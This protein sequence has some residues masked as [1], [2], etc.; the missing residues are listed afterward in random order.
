MMTTDTQA[1]ARK[2]D[3]VLLIFRGYE[4]VW[5]IDRVSA[6]AN[7]RGDEEWIELPDGLLCAGAPHGHHGAF[8]GRDASGDSCG[9][10]DE[11]DDGYYEDDVEY[12]D[13]DTRERSSHG[14]HVSFEGATAVSVDELFGMSDDER[15]SFHARQLRKLGLADKSGGAKVIWSMIENFQAFSP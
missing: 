3:G 4:G 2:L 14:T 5:M 12:L 10:G 7:D 6:P 11:R 13:R 8:S 9:E 15:R 1:I